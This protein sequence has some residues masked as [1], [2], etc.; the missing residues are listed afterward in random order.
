MFSKSNNVNSA[1]L[2]GY[3]ADIKF[4]NE[5]TEKAELFAVGSEINESSK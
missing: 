2:K 3:Y 4:T 1:S 5:S